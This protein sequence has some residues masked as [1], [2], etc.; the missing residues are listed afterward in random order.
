[1]SRG[2]DIAG[3]QSDTPR[4]R[5]PLS[6]PVELATLQDFRDASSYLWSHDNIAGL[7]GDTPRRQDPLVGAKVVASLGPLGRVTPQDS[8]DALLCTWFSNCGRG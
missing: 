5:D 3:L 2:R 4:R 7:K 8:R 1:M 6:T